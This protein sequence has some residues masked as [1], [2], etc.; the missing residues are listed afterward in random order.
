MADETEAP[1]AEASE[2]ED[3][4]AKKGLLGN[5][6]ILF[7]GLGGLL[8]VLIAVAALLLFVASL[9]SLVFRRGERVLERSL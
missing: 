9:L 8:V 4:P 6:L 7:G 2:E 1:E 5:P 3:A